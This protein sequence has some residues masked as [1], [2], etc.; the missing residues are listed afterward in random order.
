M[1]PFTWPP[2]CLGQQAPLWGSPLTC[3]PDLPASGS[4]GDYPPL[5]HQLLQDL[6]CL[7]LLLFAQATITFEVALTDEALLYLAWPPTA[8]RSDAA[9]VLAVTTFTATRSSPEV[10][11]PTS[12]RPGSRWPPWAASSSLFS[13][14][15]D[16]PCGLHLSTCSAQTRTRMGCLRKPPGVELIPTVD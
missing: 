16:R 3:L 4:L 6:C 12:S 1:S 2:G 8:A 13:E 14:E 10:L 5:F 15:D 7:A 11:A 9:V